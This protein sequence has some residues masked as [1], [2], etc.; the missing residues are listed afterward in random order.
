MRWFEF[1]FL[2]I[3]LFHKLISILTILAVTIAQD[4]SVGRRV[5]SFIGMRGKKSDI[6]IEKEI[7]MID[8]DGNDKADDNA[9]DFRSQM[10]KRAHLGFQGTRGKKMSELPF[11]R[12]VGFTGR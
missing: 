11:K 10:T 7:P 2:Q 3:M 9:D 1:L 5:P 12:Y 4:P 8:L 6:Y